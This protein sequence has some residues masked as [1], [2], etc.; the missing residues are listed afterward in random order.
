MLLAGRIQEREREKTD[1][2]TDRQRLKPKME[3][4]YIAVTRAEAKCGTLGRTALQCLTNVQLH[5]TYPRGR[6]RKSSHGGGREEGEPGK[7]LFLR[8]QWETQSVFPCPAESRG[9]FSW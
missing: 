6:Q 5:I 8:E 2:W 9:C 1:G 4:M 7:Y 3:V